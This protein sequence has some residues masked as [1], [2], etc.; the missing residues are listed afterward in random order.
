MPPL[1][2]KSVAIVKAALQR[3]SSNAQAEE[4]TGVN[5]AALG[6]IVFQVPTEQQ[7]L[8]QLTHPIA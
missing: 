6:P 8:E 7:W 4:G 1:H 2:S 5:Q 3:Y